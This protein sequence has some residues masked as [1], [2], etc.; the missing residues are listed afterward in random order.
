MKNFTFKLLQQLNKKK[1]DKGFTLIELL[2]VIII[3]GILSA[4]ALPA[5]LNQAAKAKQSEAKQT[6]GALNR[7]QQAYRLES[8]EFAPEVDLLALGVEID[9]TNYAYG[10]DGSATTGNGE[11]AF[12]FNNLEGTDFTETAGIGARAKDTAAVRDYDGATGATEDSEGNATTVT[13]ICEETAPQ[14]DD[15]DMSYSF[16]DGLGCDAGNQ[17]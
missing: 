11:F 6:L 14:D 17:L 1:A 12:N 16:A 4:I 2:V 8:P 7:G 13:V 9:T 5:F 10:D 3:I 15:Q